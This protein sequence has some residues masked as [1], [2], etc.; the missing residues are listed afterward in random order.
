MVS[1]FE[2]ANMLAQRPLYELHILSESGGLG[3]FPC[4]IAKWWPADFG[5]YG[6]LIIRMAWHAAG[7]YRIADRRS[8]RRFWPAALRTAE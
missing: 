3:E 8:G 2:S 7:T 1:V 6:G 4:S 5:H